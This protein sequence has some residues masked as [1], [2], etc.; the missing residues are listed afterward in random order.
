MAYIEKL[1]NNIWVQF[2]IP[3]LLA[4]AVTWLTLHPYIEVSYRTPFLLYFGVIFIS[5]AIGGS[6]SSIVATLSCVILSFIFLLPGY[7]P[8]SEFFGIGTCIFLAEG[9]LLSG[10][11]R[12]VEKIQQKLSESE[13]RFR[14]IIEKSA[15]GMLMTDNSGKIEYLS[16]AVITLLNQESGKLVGKRIQE[17]IHPDEVLEFEDQL[18]KLS[19]KEVSEFEFLRQVKTKGDRWIWIE[20][21]AMD[22][23]AEKSIRTFVFQFRDVTSRIELEMQ[24]EDF[25]QITSHELKTPVT[26]IKGFVQVLKKRHQKEQREQDMMMLSRIENQSEK[27]VKLIED[28]LDV[29]RIKNGELPYHFSLFD[30][31]AYFTETIAIYQT[32]YPNY[33]FTFTSQ[34]P[35]YVYGDKDRIAQVVSNLLNN[36]IKYSPGKTSLEICV[37]TENGRTKATIKDQGL[38]I[39]KDQQEKIF[40]R[41]YRISTLPKEAHNGLG[42][43]LY[44]SK[45][46][47]K[48]HGGQIGVNGQTG[49]G[50]EFWFTLDTV[51]QQREINLRFENSN[52]KL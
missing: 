36:A 37:H 8:N 1:Q 31:S 34:G 51:K 40:E 32:I 6:R 26:S 15:E 4:A 30:L 20:G 39:P 2:S 14:G 28:L 29:T 41:F 23:R 17:L 27:L 46:I 25:V 50:S 48:K 16:P 21:L 12:R 33:T 5:A 3:I 38:G 13:Q 52:T 7:S 49:S 19:R 35:A 18:H 42:I 22:L 10:L 24:K 11:F 43:G 47:I 9:L 45:E 44:I